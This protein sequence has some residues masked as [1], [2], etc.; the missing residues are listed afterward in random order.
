M[1]QYI[2]IL[3]TLVNQSALAINLSELASLAK[4]K[5][6]REGIES[7]VK[8]V[9]VADQ[10]ELI[11]VLKSKSGEIREIYKYLPANGGT[12]GDVKRWLI[13]SDGSIVE[14][15]YKVTGTAKGTAS[16]EIEELPYVR[17]N[18][19]WGKIDWKY[20]MTSSGRGVTEIKPIGVSHKYK[21]LGSDVTESETHFVMIKTDYHASFP[22]AMEIKDKNIVMMETQRIKSNELDI[23]AKLSNDFKDYAQ[24]MV[25]MDKKLPNGQI[26]VFNEMFH[27]PK[28]EG[29]V[30][31]FRFNPSGTKLVVDT[32]KGQQLTYRIEAGR[33]FDNGRVIDHKDGA[34]AN[35]L[36]RRE[37]ISLVDYIADQTVIAGRKE[38]VVPVHGIAV[39]LE[40]A[41]ATAAK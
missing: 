21:V 26:R 16:S 32:S 25:R 37:T 2:I 6:S 35:T 29:A 41:V 40:A 28:F 7:L 1:K 3:L 11:H 13:K 9:E 30:L 4:G 18:Y 23:I 5:L 17:D 8:A 20:F 33:I 12:G 34:L 19:A 15:S 10:R 39:D 27:I 24:I 31:R 36:V 38:A 22:R 14:Q